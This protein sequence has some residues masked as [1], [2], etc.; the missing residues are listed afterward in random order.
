MKNHKKEGKFWEN[1]IIKR[2]L[3]FY[4]KTNKRENNCFFIADNSV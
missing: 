4:N 3:E 2:S 1:L